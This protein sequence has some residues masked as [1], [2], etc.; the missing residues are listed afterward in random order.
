[1]IVLK[2]IIIKYILGYCIGLYFV[3]VFF[4]LREIVD[5]KLVLINIFMFVFFWKMV[6]SFF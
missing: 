1:M 5:V 6:C 3:I 4:F 2:E